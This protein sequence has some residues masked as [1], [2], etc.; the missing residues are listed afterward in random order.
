[1]KIKTLN[2]N[3]SQYQVFLINLLKKKKLI[4]SILSR[5]KI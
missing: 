3:F 1:M 5:N 2:N 4:R